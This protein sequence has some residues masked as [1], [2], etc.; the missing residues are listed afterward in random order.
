VTNSRKT[1]SAVVI[2]W[3]EEERLRACL[4]S[5]AW[6]DEIVVVDAESQDKTVEVA[7]EFTDRILVQPWLGFAAQKNFAVDQARGEWILSVDADEEVSLDLRREVEAILAA[8]VT[9]AGYAI[10]RR[11]IFWDRWIRHGG[12][13]PDWQTRLF[14]RGRGR[15]VQRAVHES[16]EIAGPLTRLRGPLVHKSYRSI[17]EFLERANRYSSLAADDLARSGARVGGGQVVLRPLG[18]FLSMYLLRRG[19]LDGMPGLLLAGL[20]AYY[21]FI[22][23]AKLWEKTRG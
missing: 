11:N 23:C 13:Y 14:Q 8:P 18:R 7:R 16:V 17:A 1:C 12:L 4:A 9:A 2:T 15:F 6:V 21:V 19:F 10:P 22:R 5:L 20:Y 3:N